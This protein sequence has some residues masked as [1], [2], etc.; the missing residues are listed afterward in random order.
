MPHPS[1]LRTTARMDIKD[2]IYLLCIHRASERAYRANACFSIWH[3]RAPPWALHETSTNNSSP[4]RDN[5]ALSIHPPGEAVLNTISGFEE[6]LA[7]TY[8]GREQWSAC[9]TRRHRKPAEY[10][11]QSAHNVDQEQGH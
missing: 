9:Q 4:D 11:R 10:Q 5:L 3:R 8:T 1:P 7:E 2:K 6:V